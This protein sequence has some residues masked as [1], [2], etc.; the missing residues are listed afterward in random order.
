VI[1]GWASA[2]TTAA[3][4]RR[5][6]ASSGTLAAVSKRQGPGRQTYPAN[7]L[8]HPAA[9]QQPAWG[10]AGAAGQRGAVAGEE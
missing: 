2:A 4:D 10:R 8:L 9:G 1:L 5:A 6:A 7:L 3:A